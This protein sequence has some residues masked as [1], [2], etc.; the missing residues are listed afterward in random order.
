[1]TFVNKERFLSQDAM[2]RESMPPQAVETPLRLNDR[3]QIA[4]KGREEISATYVS[5]VQNISSGDVVIQ[6][7]NSR[8]VRAPLQENS[9][10]RIYFI[11]KSEA[12]EIDARVLNLTAYPHYLVLIRCEGQPR[13]I[14]R[15]D[16][17]R[18]PAMI[19]V[20]LTARLAMLSATPEERAAYAIT[21]TTVDISGGGFNIHNSMP[22]EMDSL[23]DVKMNIPTLEK[24]LS[25]TAK[26]VRVEPALNR[27]KDT[28]YDIGFDFIMLEEPVRRQI[29][30]YV[31]RFQ[32]NMLARRR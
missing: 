4:I 25:V 16:Y 23:Y 22:L 15:R 14:Q 1:L 19:D 2:Q 17:V 32:Q 30:K 20:R 5:R 13:K 11:K 21:T 6:W 28:Y 9:L 7:P 3:L 29:V 18:V 8:G 12:L 27:M 10:L 31:F 26:V 24:P